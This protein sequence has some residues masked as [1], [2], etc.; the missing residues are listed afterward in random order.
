MT[1][2]DAI[3]WLKLLRKNAEKRDAH[4]ITEALNM[5]IKIFDPDCDTCEH[6][7]KLGDWCR[8]CGESNYQPKDEPQ[9]FIAC[10]IQEENEEYFEWLY[11]DEP[12]MYYPQVDG[13]TPSVI[14]Q[15]EPT[16][17]KM[18]QVDEPQICEWCKFYDGENC[19]SQEPCKA[20][21][22]LKTE[23]QT[24]RP[25]GEWKPKNHHT[26]YCSN[27][28]FEETQWRTADYN[29]CPSCGARMKGVDDEHTV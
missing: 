17:S 10:P 14:I 4:N 19:F 29:F 11:K 12:T 27:C 24:E 21:L 22:Y 18:E 5:A 15:D 6:Q 3:Y 2:E 23:P 1:I 25:Q 8:T 20:M 13:I 9:N 26:D 7:G 16:I 28:G